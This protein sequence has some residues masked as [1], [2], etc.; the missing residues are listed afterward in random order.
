MK[1]KRF[2]ISFWNKPPDPRWQENQDGLSK[3]AFRNHVE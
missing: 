1:K 3:T 2:E